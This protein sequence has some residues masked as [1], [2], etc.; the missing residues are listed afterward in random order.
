MPTTVNIATNFEGEVAG[1]YMAPMIREANTIKENLVTVLPNITAP[2]FVRKIET[3]NGFVDYVCGFTPA[4]SITISERELNPKKIKEDRQLCKEDFRQLWTAQEMG[5][6]AHND[7]L[8]ATEQAAILADIGNR[9]ALKID[10]EI[11]N[12]DGS[13]GKLAG[14]IPALLAD[15]D[16][17]DVVGEVITAENVQAELGKFIDAHTDEIM[18]APDHVYGVSTNVLRALKR[19]Y[20]NQARSNGT[21]STGSDVEFDGHQLTAIKGLPANTM[22]GYNRSNLM[23]GTG[24]LADHNEIKVI[25]EDEIGL[26][27]GMI[28]MKTVLTGGVQYAYGGEV[29]LYSVPAV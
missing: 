17:I 18:E 22:I 3:E 21:F 24:L 2:Q 14:F 1:K 5:F 4:G 20:G 15:A 7:N 12:G 16:V 19:S 29:V 23:F 13:D 26:L 8:P 6:S 9:I 28:R 27:T 11:W 10:R 25:D